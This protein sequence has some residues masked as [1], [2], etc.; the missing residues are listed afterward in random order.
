MWENI[1]QDKTRQVWVIFFFF[2]LLLFDLGFTALSRIFHLYRADRSSKVGE[3][4]RAGEKNQLT[5]RKQNLAFPRVL[6]EARTT[7]VRNLMD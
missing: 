5:I 3:S 4:W 2:L 7:A 6:S 1:R